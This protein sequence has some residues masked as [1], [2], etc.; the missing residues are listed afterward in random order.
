MII[1]PRKKKIVRILYTIA[2]IF[3]IL[4][5]LALYILPFSS[6]SKSFGY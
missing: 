2:S 6:V 1:D 5:M 4:G 3:V